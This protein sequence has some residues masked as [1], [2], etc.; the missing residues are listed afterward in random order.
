MTPLNLILTLLVTSKASAGEKWS[1]FLVA[2]RSPAAGFGTSCRK[3]N[4]DSLS[5]TEK[6]SV[7]EVK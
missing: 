4:A 5:Y 2:K 3:D 6:V 1:L 7:V